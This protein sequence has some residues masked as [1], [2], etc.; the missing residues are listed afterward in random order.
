MAR[1]VSVHDF[2]KRFLR[3]ALISL[4]Y[5]INATPRFAV[6]S[7]SLCPPL[8]EIPV[9]AIIHR[10]VPGFVEDDRWMKRYSNLAEFNSCN[11]KFESL[12]L[13]IFILFFFFNYICSLVPFATN[14]VLA[15]LHNVL[16]HQSHRVFQGLPLVTEPNPD[17]FSIVSEALRQV[18]DFVTWNERR[19][20]L[21]KLRS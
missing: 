1:R 19:K 7:F 2:L 3:N 11:V 20:Q 4:N 9:H 18:R 12:K 16:R 17:H 10:S 8:F 5:F 15:L 13:L 6:T 21:V 14:L